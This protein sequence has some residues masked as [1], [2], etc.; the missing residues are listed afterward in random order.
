MTIVI[1]LF[2]SLLIFTLFKVFEDKITLY[3]LPKLCIFTFM[4]CEILATLTL[5][6]FH[7]F[8]LQPFKLQIK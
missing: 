4:P 2:L 6:V 1:V 7:L 8:Y 5:T 3:Y